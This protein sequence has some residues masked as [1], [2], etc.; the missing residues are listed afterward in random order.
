[1]GALTVL[2]RDKSTGWDSK[3]INTRIDQ[4]MV[5]LAGQKS[6]RIAFRIS[7]WCLTDCTKELQQIGWNCCLWGAVQWHCNTNRQWW[8]RTKTIRC[9]GKMITNE[10]IR[11]QLQL[12]SGSKCSERGF[13]GADKLEGTIF[14]GRSPDNKA[15]TSCYFPLLFDC[16]M[17]IQIILSFG[18]DW[19]RCVGQFPFWRL[20]QWVSFRQARSPTVCYPK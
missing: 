13:L 14:S 7:H 8:V 6:S 2:D 11:I 10:K 16:S 18:K 17:S 4:K 3:P 15:N 12:R 20:S 19:E 9:R 1:M 5:S